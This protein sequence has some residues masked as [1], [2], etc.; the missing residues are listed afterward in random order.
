MEKNLSLALRL[1]E[2]CICDGR[3]L[4]AHPSL[5]D[6]LLLVLVTFGCMTHARE[7]FDLLDVHTSETVDALISGYVKKGEMTNAIFIYMKMRGNHAIRL[8]GASYIMLLKACAIV[9]GAEV[10]QYLHRDVA[11]LG[12]L[13]SNILVVSALIEMYINHGFLEYAQKVIDKLSG[14][15][16]VSWTLLMTGYV[17][18][19]FF[20]EAFSCYEK[21]QGAGIFP[22]ALAFVCALRAC[23]SIGEATKGM[24]THMD[25][26]KKGYQNHPFVGNA[27]VD[28]YSKCGLLETAK[29]VLFSL[30]D[31]DIVAWNALIAGYT[32]YGHGEK[33]LH[34]FHEMQ[35]QGICSNHVTFVHSLKSCYLTA[36]HVK[37]CEIN[38]EILK[39]GFET[40]ALVR[41]TLVNM[42][43]KCGFLEDAQALFDMAVSPDEVLCN[44][45]MAGYVEQKSSNEALHF[46]E[47]IQHEGRPLSVVTFVLGLKSCGGETLLG[48]GQEIHADIVMKGM[49]AELLLGGAILDMYCKCGALSEAECVFERVPAQD[50]I[51]WTTLMAGYSDHGYNELILDCYEKMQ[52]NW[53]P[54]NTIAYACVLNAC[55]DVRAADL[56]LKLHSDIICKGFD[57]DILLGNTLVEMYAKC[58]WLTTAQFLFDSLLI[59]EPTSYHSLI[60]G[61]L[62]QGDGDNAWDCLER[63]QVDNIY[64]NTSTMICC[65]RVCRITGST[66]RGQWLHLEIVK[67]GLEKE[68]L[69]GNALVDMYAKCGFV[70]YAHVLFLKLHNPSVVSWS[71]L[72]SGYALLGKCEVVFN[73]LGNMI[74]DGVMPNLITGVSILNACNHAGFINEGCLFFK[75]MSSDWGLVPD[76]EHYTCMVDLLGRMGDTAN[77]LLILQEMPMQPDIVSWQKFLGACVKWGDTELGRHAFNHSVWIDEKETSIYVYMYNIIVSGIDHYPQP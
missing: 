19:G 49:E 48:K 46:F 36:N 73:L 12:L 27:L 54:L 2:A 44:A 45:L 10:G 34:V 14:V 39:K 23:G 11:K 15:D 38:M 26:L 47:L 5:G 4:L 3:F 17:K 71:S 37:G 31:R 50:V 69:V 68:L 65:L 70:K 56:G 61:Y 29:K 16:V 64:M 7:V 52:N 33:A 66:L 40:E 63:L 75:L 51:S 58:G 77:A 30:S 59:R 72:I 60:L 35:C 76:V 42:Y 74:Q 20:K 22:D 41:S 6:Q 24:N 25:I 43:A 67:R 32:K 18:H 57:D 62:E 1:H 53:V 13:D 28:M 55:G 21:M 8:S 9:H